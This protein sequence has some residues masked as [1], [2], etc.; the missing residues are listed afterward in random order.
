MNGLKFLSWDPRMSVCTIEGMVQAGNDMIKDGL[1]KRDKPFVADEIVDKAVLERVIAKA[2][3]LL[4]RPAA[5]AEDARR[6]QGQAG[7]L[8][9][10]MGMTRERPSVTAVCPFR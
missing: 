6:V 8:S 7:G 3:G 2:S 10:G 9:V 1:I 5:A 4:R